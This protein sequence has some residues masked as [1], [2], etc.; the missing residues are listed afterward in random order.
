MLYYVSSD[1]T[2]YPPGTAFVRDVFIKFTRD[3]M[4][5]FESALAGASASMKADN[6]VYSLTNGDKTLYV[7]C[8]GENIRFGWTLEEHGS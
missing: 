5:D 6:T 7:E 1:V 2:Q 8:T 4:Q 3:D